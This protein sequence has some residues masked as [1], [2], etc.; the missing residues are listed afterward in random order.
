MK[1]HLYWQL[2][3]EKVKHRTL[4]FKKKKKEITEES[5][6]LF[7]LILQEPFLHATRIYIQHICYVQ[8]SDQRD[9]VFEAFFLHYKTLKVYAFAVVRL[10]LYD[11]F[12]I[13]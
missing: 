13:R 7:S 5:L 4:N 3:K 1:I 12:T 6:F 10:N 11:D 8:I 2:L 9:Y